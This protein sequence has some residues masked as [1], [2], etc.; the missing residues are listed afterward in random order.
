MKLSGITLGWLSRNLTFLRRQV[1]WL[2]HQVVQ[3]ILPG[4]ISSGFNCRVKYC[5]HDEPRM[6]VGGQLPPMSGS[7]LIIAVG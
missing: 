6:K 3:C 1:W 2:V 7:C 5:E 4:Y